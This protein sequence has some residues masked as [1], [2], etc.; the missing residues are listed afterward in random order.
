MKKSR[1]VTVSLLSSV[2]ALMSGCSRE[3][4]FHAYRNASGQ[5]V[6]QETGE[7][8]DPRAC[9]GSGGGY[10]GGVHY[11]YSPG[12]SAPAAGSQ[13]ADSTVRGVF[14]ASAEAAHAG[15]AG[16]GAGE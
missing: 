6:S 10:Y 4:T 3:R 1:A 8:V 12:G 5:C 15:G 2:A 16:E 11:V 7:P 9:S 13:P 14:G